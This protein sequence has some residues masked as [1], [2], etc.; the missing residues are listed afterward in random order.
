MEEIISE[1]SEERAAAINEK[2][3]IFIEQAAQKKWWF[4]MQRGETTAEHIS[5][6]FSM[7]EIKEHWRSVYKSYFVILKKMRIFYGKDYV[8]NDDYRKCHD[9]IANMFMHDV[10]DN[11][12]SMTAEIVNKY[13]TIYDPVAS[14][15]MTETDIY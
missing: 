1:Y 7:H 11:Y 10:R 15:D 9:V 13:L 12:N 8:N 14:D 4:A 3:A 6:Y 5:K 2:K